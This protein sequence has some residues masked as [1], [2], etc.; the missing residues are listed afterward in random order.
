VQVVFWVFMLWFLPS[1]LVAGGPIDEIRRAL[2]RYLVTVPTENQLLDIVPGNLVGGLRAID[3]YARWFTTEEYT[4]QQNAGAA[5][6]I[7]AA[8]VEWNDRFVI[9]PYVGGPL[10]RQGL[11]GPSYLRAVDEGAVDVLGLSEVARRLQGKAG[12]WV[13][14][15]VS[16]P[17]ESFT[18]EFRVQRSAYRWTTVERVKGGDQPL[19]RVRGF[20]S[21]ETRALLSVALEEQIVTQKPVVIDLRDSPGGDLFEGL[22]SAALFVSQGERLASTRDRNRGIQHY[23]SPAGG[24]FRPKALDLWVGPGTA[25]A[26]EVFAGILQ[27]RGLAR[28]VG[29]RTRGKCSSQTDVTL[30]DRSVLRLTNRDVIFPGGTTCSGDGL[31]PDVRVEGEYIVDDVTL[32]HASRIGR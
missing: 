27:Q 5:T 24:K 14:I 12:T 23:V 6:G 25:S 7:G 10:S 9:V 32:L 19:I 31:I 21:R 8:L 20:K 16:G 3:P 13:Q 30:S 26:A 15:V 29:V 18:R 2:E 4:R 11:T 22:D 28:L 17:E 1:V